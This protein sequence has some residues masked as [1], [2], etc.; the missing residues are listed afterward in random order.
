MFVQSEIPVEKLMI[1]NGKSLNSGHE[2]MK[3]VNI[4]SLPLY[5]VQRYL[6]S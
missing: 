3:Y 5:S 4:N 6:D 1:D 2:L